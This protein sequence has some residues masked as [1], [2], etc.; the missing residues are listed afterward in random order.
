MC[1]VIVVD[2]ESCQSTRHG[3][4]AYI[5]DHCLRYLHNYVLFYQ[6]I[7]NNL[8]THCKICYLERSHLLNLWHRVSF[9]SYYISFIYIASRLLFFNLYFP[10]YTT[11][12]QKIITL[13]SLSDLSFAIG[14][15]GIDN[16]FIAL[17]ARFLFVCAGTRRLAC[18]LLLD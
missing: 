9:P 6:L 16:P 7:G 11:K 8:F 13:L 18:N 12:I 4:D 3:R 15:E 1:G 10:I 17:V 2:A 5:H 14:C